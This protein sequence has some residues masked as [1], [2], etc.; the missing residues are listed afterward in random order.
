M[1]VPVFKNKHKYSSVIKPEE[2]LSYVFSAGNFKNFKAPKSA[3]LC[4]DA[5]LTRYVFKNFKPK[6]IRF[7]RNIYLL[8]DFDGIAFAGNFPYGA[9]AA[10]GFLELLTAHGIKKFISVG[11]A[12][13]LQ[14]KSKAG[15]TVICQKAIRDEGTSYHYL[16]SSKYSYPCKKLT[17][18]IIGTAKKEKLDFY[19]G[20]SWTTDAPYRETTAEVK[21]YS[22]EKVLTVDMEASALFAVAKYRKA[23]LS[24][25]FTISDVVAEKNWKPKMFARQVNEGLKKIFH[26]ALNVLK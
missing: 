1:T 12:G 11:I 5:D 26:L 16:P 19:Y 6:K 14:D 15:D 20:T 13:G 21:R 4:Y 24:C 2:M 23:A 17:R 25:V 3:I 18:E 9:S 22:A 10:C 7:F 8:A